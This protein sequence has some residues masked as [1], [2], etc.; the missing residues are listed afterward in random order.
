MQLVSATLGVG[1][2]GEVGIWSWNVLTLGGP[3]PVSAAFVVGEVA[4][5][6]ADVFWCDFDEFIIFNK[7]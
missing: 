3:G 1:L 4:F 2:K 6:E 7:F 5:A